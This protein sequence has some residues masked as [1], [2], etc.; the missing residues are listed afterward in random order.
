MNALSWHARMAWFEAKRLLFRPRFLFVCLASLLWAL[1]D[2]SWRHLD[3]ET[4]WLFFEVLVSD[5]P[6]YRFLLPVLVAIVSADALAVDL[7]TGYMA[8]VLS[9]KIQRRHY[10][11]HKG[12]AMILVA[13]LATAIRYAWLIL[14]ALIRFPV[15]E[16]RSHLGIDPQYLPGPFPL[17]FYTHPTFN[18]L[19]GVLMI[20]LGTGVLATFG[21]VT[22]ALGGNVYLSS[23]MPVAFYFIATFSFPLNAEAVYN[24]SHHILLNPEFN[25]NVWTHYATYSGHQYYLLIWFAYWFT[26]AAV[27]LCTG[28]VVAERRELG[29]GGA[30]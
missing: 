29:L 21:F 8:L 24:H 18:T 1:Q 5:S 16:V 12:V 23:A 15:H 7:E 4:P 17:L 10:L 27:S 14:I 19:V 6:V 30:S 28:V 3:A 20:C 13:A 9:R 25:L 11:W 26:I 22:A 2:T